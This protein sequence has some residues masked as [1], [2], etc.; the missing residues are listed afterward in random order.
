MKNPIELY[1]N[2][3]QSMRALPNF[4]LYKIVP[5]PGKRPKK[6]PYD[7]ATLSAFE[8]E[9]KDSD[10]VNFESAIQALAENPEFDGLGFIM[11]RGQKIH[12]LDSD[13]VSRLNGSPAKILECL[14]TWAEWSQSG[15]GWHF[16]MFGDI[17]ATI[18]TSAYQ[19]YQAGQFIALTGRTV[20]GAAAEIADCTASF[21]MA[22]EIAGLVWK[23]TQDNAQPGA[24][25]PAGAALSDTQVLE[26]AYHSKNGDETK[27]IFEGGI[28]GGGDT[29]ETGVLMSILSR[30]AP[31]CS[32]MAQLCR[33]S[34]Q[35]SHYSERW[36]KPSSGGKSQLEYSAEKAFKNRPFTY[37][38]RA[39]T[40]R[41]D[42]ARA[43]TAR[44]DTARADTARA[45]WYQA[46]GKD[47]TKLKIDQLELI[48]FLQ[49]NGFARIWIEQQRSILVKIADNVAKEQTPEQ[50]RDFVLLRV[51][52]LP[53]QITEDFTKEDLERVLISAQN[54]YFSETYLKT[55]NACNKPFHI[56]KSDIIYIYYRNGYTETTKGGTKLKPYS[57]LDG[58]IWESQIHDRDYKQLL[59]SQLES[60]I[61]YR[62]Q[63]NIC[64]PPEIRLGNVSTE[65]QE[66]IENRLKSLRT[67]IGYLIHRHST[68]TTIK[69]VV[70]NDEK[71][72]IDE[73]RGGEGRS[74]K[75]L[76]MQGLQHIRNVT[77]IDG[78]SFKRDSQFKFQDLSLQTDVAF[79]DDP[80]RKFDIE[81][82]YSVLSNGYTI[83]KKGKDRIKLP[84]PIKT[85]IATNF[86][87]MGNTASDIGRR[88]EIEASPY[89]S[90]QYTP[91]NEFGG[92]LFKEW[93]D[94]E[95][96]KFDNYM[97]SCCIDYLNFGL[98]E[99]KHKN[100]ELRKLIQ[101]TCHEFV[102]FANDYITINEEHNRSEMFD[103][104]IGE[105]RYEKLTMN[106]F[107]KW[108]NEY[109][110]YKGCIRLDEKLGTIRKS[111][112]ERFF[113]LKTDEKIQA[114]RAGQIPAC[115]EKC[116][117]AQL[118]WFSEMLSRAPGEL[119]VSINSQYDRV[120]K[121]AHKAEKD[122]SKREN[123]AIAAAN[124][125]LIEMIEDIEAGR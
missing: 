124:K 20:D 19:L 94:S 38:A 41:A 40:A 47:G 29:S 27:R 91:A 8:G 71:I 12:C 13:G 79:F 104:F 31:F 11:K 84:Q 119:R 10:G 107:T 90:L 118:K 15:D 64:S 43:D 80:D 18:N 100:L 73:R 120:Y 81:V 48:R 101:G 77:Q 51:R 54:V 3:P 98:V 30:L 76:T 24:A 86:V 52:S 67:A 116:D 17:P 35:S 39:D 83:E 7:V 105:H 32:D 66:E 72:S 96:A 74:G 95:W 69:A 22:A 78:K 33:V 103:K 57:E 5:V 106:S 55:V 82:L 37:T 53:L 85:V 62:F 49:E 28:H 9:R 45:F 6:I 89:Y 36:E 122:E 56:D 65:K 87:I 68:P 63:K 108:L 123:V 58:I 1:Q 50:I 114:Y 113:T 21:P 110:Q 2:I 92:E 99:C 121:D 23:K 117:K 25:L 93:K 4:C 97:H 14:K 61:F 125:A 88:F 70:F 46:K 60:G 75:G 34:R 42:T 115:L 112:G 59:N 109:A 44:A 16:F 111:N 26:I 102:E